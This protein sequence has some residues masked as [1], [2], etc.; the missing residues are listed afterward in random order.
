[1]ELWNWGLPFRQTGRSVWPFFPGK[2]ATNSKDVCPMK[3]ARNYPRRALEC[4]AFAKNARSEEERNELLA[5]ANTLERL[6]LKNPQK[7][8]QKSEAES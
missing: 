8:P 4:F 3:T 1:M 2:M 6:A 5:M 7:A